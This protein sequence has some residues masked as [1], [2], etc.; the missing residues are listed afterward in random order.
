VI[1]RPEIGVAL[2]TILQ[3]YLAAP[4]TIPFY[5]IIPEIRREYIEP[6]PAEP[7][8]FCQNPKWGASLWYQVDIE[9]QLGGRV[10]LE[11]VPGL[12]MWLVTGKW[13]ASN[14]EKYATILPKRPLIK[15]QYLGY[16]K[17]RSIP[18]GF[19]SEC[20]VGEKVKAIPPQI[21]ASEREEIDARYKTMDRD[22]ATG[23]TWNPSEDDEEDKQHQPLTLNT[24]IE[25]AISSKMDQPLSPRKRSQG[26]TQGD[27]E[28][29]E[30]FYT[31]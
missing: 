18:M 31:L 12:A 14:V 11:E 24:Q 30:R 7:F 16:Y 25:R 5:A 3:A 28:G 17:P 26:D 10:A 21:T 23:K 2:Y 15:P 29:E 8:N 6:K 22:E 20:C 1:V 13:S 9:V 27:T 19:V 4:I